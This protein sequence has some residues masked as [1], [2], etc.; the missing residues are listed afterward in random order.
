MMLINKKSEKNTASKS[1][2]N[3]SGHWVS[4]GYNKTSTLAFQWGEN[5]FYVKSYAQKTNE[6]NIRKTFRG[7][8]TKVLYRCSLRDPEI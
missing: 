1:Q 4:C 3:C 7:C 8:L 6:E 5:A 2:F